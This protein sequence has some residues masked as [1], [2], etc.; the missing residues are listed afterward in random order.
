MN[1]SPPVV[2]VPGFW[3]G[4]WCW[5]PVA[6]QLTARGIRSVAADIDGHA[7][8]GRAMR[9]RWARPFFDE[10]SFAT[11][12]SPVA[13]ITASGAAAALADRVRKEGGGRPCLVVAHGMGGVVA[14]ALAE[15]APELV[16]GLVYV[17]AYAPVNGVPAGSYRTCPENVAEKAL[18]LLVTEPELIGAARIDFGDPE[19]R[20]EIKEAFYNDLDDQAADAAMALLS[21]DGPAGIAGERLTVTEARFGRILHS[22][23]TCSRDNVVPLA[24]QRH[25]IKEIDAVSVFPTAVTELDSSHAPFLSRPVALSEAIADA[26][27]VHAEAA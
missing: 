22:Y 5:G 8:R 26:S 3:H 19:R 2:L 7:L 21:P 23:V 12:P 17:S 11:E 10:R 15:L 18:Q 24:L 1:D 13:R 16:A 14:T 9:A 4:G 20:D 6:E 27:G 25:F